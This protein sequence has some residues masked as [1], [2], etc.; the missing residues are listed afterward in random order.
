MTSFI[1]GFFQLMGT[2]QATDDPPTSAK[3]YLQVFDSCAP[4]GSLGNGVFVPCEIRL[5]PKGQEVEGAVIF[6]HGRFSVV[7]PNDGNE[8]FL[9][10]EAHDFVIM[11][12]DIDP[13]SDDIPDDLC[14]S[15]TLL[16]RVVPT[17]P[18]PA[19]TQDKFFTL[20]VSDY[21]RDHTQTFRIRCA[22]PSLALNI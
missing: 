8:L 19:P 13:T 12:M 16:G 2:H 15:L 7:S 14:A 5:F 11:K 21:I 10:V 9:Q 6:A 17:A 1:D 4:L 20:E 22:Q 3:S 18:E